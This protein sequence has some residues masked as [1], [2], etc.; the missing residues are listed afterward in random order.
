M[1]V[2]SPCIAKTSFRPKGLVVAVRKDASSR[3]Y[4]TRVKQRTPLVPV[5]LTLDLGG[6]FLWVDCEK[7][8]VSS[9][10]KPVRCGSAA[11]A[12]TQS[13]GC[14]YCD[15]PPKPGCSNNSCSAIPD[16][17]VV[18]EATVGDFTRD[19]LSIQS[20]TGRLLTIPNLIFTCTYTSLLKGLAAGVKGMAGLGWSKVSLPSQFSSAFSFPRKFAICLSSSTSAHG[21]VLFGDAP[22]VFLP[23]LDIS[24][25][26]IYTPL[27]KNPV[28]TASAHYAGHPSSD[29]F[30]GVKS[31]RI[32]LQPVP[33]NTTL[34]SIHKEGRGG[35]K[36]STVNPYS[37][38]ER[39]IYKAVIGAFGK[40]LKDVPRA[41]AV[42]PFELCFKSSSL[43]ST[44]VGAAVPNIDLLLHNKD[45]VW[46]IF[47]ANSMVHVSDEATCLGFVDG[48]VEPTTSIVIGAHQIEDNLL[49][50]D[51]A[52][53][54]LGFTSSLLF[55]M[56]YACSGD[57]KLVI[58][59]K[60][61]SC[62]T[63]QLPLILLSLNNGQIKID[64]P[65][66]TS[67]SGMSHPPTNPPIA[68]P[69]LAS[70]SIL[71][72][73]ELLSLSLS[74]G[75]SATFTNTNEIVEVAQHLTSL[76]SIVASLLTVPDFL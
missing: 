24:N 70:N 28:S 57:S 65:K 33:I 51:L 34:L 74:Q 59:N 64:L 42:A 4:V 61:K 38:L 66:N 54:R 40:A 1:C 9:S 75:A 13:G 8:Y 37:I 17:T 76:H 45:T 10:Y 16:N 71:L 2:L 12:L 43:G 36:I 30:I 60:Y 62:I 7:G 58:F 31:I 25:K 26:L 32:N 6:Q 22:Y 21:V 20:T 63:S 35:T 47:G 67:G 72:L 50:F 41:R 56:C 19:V 44:R 3:Q 52:A 11:C 55:S 5:K 39:S 48:G 23:G 49:H 46:T 69:S 27:I 18:R 68:A 53:S 14:G 15:G 73:R 29:Y